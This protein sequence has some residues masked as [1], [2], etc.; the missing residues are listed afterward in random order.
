MINDAEL[1]HQTGKPRNVVHAPDQPSGSVLRNPVER[2][3]YESS[4]H[5]AR[6]AYLSG[7]D[8]INGATYFNMRPNPGRANLKFANGTPEGVALST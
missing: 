6:E 3:A 2:A 8:P 1:S 7:H 5:A 4:L